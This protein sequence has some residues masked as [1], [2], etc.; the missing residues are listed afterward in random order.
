LLAFNP[1][2]I[3]YRIQQRCFALYTTSS[4]PPMHGS[5]VAMHVDMIS[6]KL[7]GVHYET[8]STHVKLRSVCKS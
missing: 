2:H 1:T 4:S 5:A 8:R 3:T 7:S 6:I